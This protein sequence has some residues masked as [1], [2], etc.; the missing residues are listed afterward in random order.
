MRKALRPRL[1]SVQGGK[2]TGV[3][4]KCGHWAMAA[5]DGC[6]S[7]DPGRQGWGALAG[8]VIKRTGAR[9]RTFKGNLPR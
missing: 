5:L 2:T 4:E 1:Q 3:Q 6:E 8:E 7:S 9:L